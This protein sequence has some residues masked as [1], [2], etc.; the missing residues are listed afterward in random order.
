[1]CE[2]FVSA[3]SCA[4][5]PILDFTSRGK[6][7]NLYVLSPLVK[8]RLVYSSYANAAEDP[9]LSGPSVLVKP[10]EHWEIMCVCVCV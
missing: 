1:M 2:P 5:L 7:C 9:Y 6:A 10:V 3:L 4:P 8:Y